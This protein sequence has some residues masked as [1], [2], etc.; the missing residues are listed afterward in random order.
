M[1]AITGFILVLLVSCHFNEREPQAMESKLMREEEIIP[2]FVHDYLRVDLPGWKFFSTKEWNDLKRNQLV[3]DTNIK[4]YILADINCDYKLDFTGIIRD[5]IGK[6]MLYQIRSINEY[7]IGHELSPPGPKYQ[8]PD[9]GLKLLD[10][11]VPYVYEDG[12]TQD[13]KCGGIES[14]SFDSCRK[15]IFYAKENGFYVTELSKIACKD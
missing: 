8:R 13:F 10:S 2:S 9:F 3:T 11:K 7:Y 1:K 15:T 12:S 14:S 5:S 6:I 4:G